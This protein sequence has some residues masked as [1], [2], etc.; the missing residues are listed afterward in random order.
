MSLAA[1]AVNAGRK[2]GIATLVGL[3]CLTSAAAAT[4]TPTAPP[5]ASASPRG[6]IPALCRPPLPPAGAHLISVTNT[7]GVRVWTYTVASKSPVQI[8]LYYLRAVPPKGY[9]IQGW[10]AGGNRVGSGGGLNA[11]SRACGYL[12]MSTAA[13]RGKPANLRVCTGAT[14][15][16][17]KRCPF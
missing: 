7:G 17:L 2:V 3:T 15:A 14:A 5:A 10:G 11:Y 8:V 9:G 1:S 16:T 13:A 6:D 4:A 12:G